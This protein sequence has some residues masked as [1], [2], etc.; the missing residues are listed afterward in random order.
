M[1][2][3]KPQGVG[4]ELW[5]PTHALLRREGW[6]VVETLALLEQQ[7][8]KWSVIPVSLRYLLPVN[9]G[10]VKV[11]QCQ[12]IV[13]SRLAFALDHLVRVWD[14]LEVAMPELRI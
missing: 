14:P 4:N 6:R 2:I 11:T 5:E 8:M 12:N 13:L 9:Q 7:G 1:R 3:R 10:I